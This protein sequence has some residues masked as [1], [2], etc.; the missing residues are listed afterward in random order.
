MVLESSGTPRVGRERQ[1]ISPRDEA[2]IKADGAQAHVELSVWQERWVL[3]TQSFN[4][5]YEKVVGDM[6]Y[7]RSESPHVHFLENW[8]SLL[9]GIIQAVGEGRG[10]GEEVKYL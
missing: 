7:L 2:V 1:V 9:E 8:R 10:E 4:C 6:E 5:R 3:S